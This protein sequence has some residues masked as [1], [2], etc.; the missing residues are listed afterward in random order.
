[1]G[2]FQLRFCLRIHLAPFLGKIN[3]NGKPTTELNIS[4]FMQKRICVNGAKIV[5]RILIMMKQSW[6]V[7]RVVT[8]HL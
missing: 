1:M 6:N 3:V 7:K 4:V 8:K 5:Y 2:F